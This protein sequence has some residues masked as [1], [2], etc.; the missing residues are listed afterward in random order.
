MKKAVYALSADPIT[1]GHVWIV[2]NAL[3]TFDHV[4]VYVASN[5]TKKHTFTIN[6]RADLVREVFRLQI[7]EHQLDVKVLFEDEFIVRQAV[8][9]QARFLVRG[10]RN[11]TDFEYEMQ[12][13]NFNSTLEPSVSTVFF[14]TPQ[15]LAGIS[16]TFVKG[17]VGLQ[18]WEDIAAKYVPEPV[19]EKLKTIERLRS[20]GSQ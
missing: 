11:A 13:A 12:M 18:G 17:L 5:S 1:N 2:S 19:L 15:H 9:Q 8:R 16:S 3:A 6:E 4:Y 7:K 20:H 10:L 14:P